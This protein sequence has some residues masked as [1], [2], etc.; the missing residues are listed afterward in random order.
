MVLIFLIDCHVIIAGIAFAIDIVDPDNYRD[1]AETIIQEDE[2]G[3]P[4][5]GPKVNGRKFL[6][7]YTN[8]EGEIRDFFEARKSRLQQ[9][10]RY[11]ASLRSLKDS[12]EALSENEIIDKKL[13]DDRQRISRYRNV[14]FHVRPREIDRFM[15]SKLEE[16]S[17]R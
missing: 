13:H 17:K 11:P 16:I 10:R 5:N 15:L 7:E 1:I 3:E 4:L 14:V 2:A 12:S 8:L 9:A 6:H